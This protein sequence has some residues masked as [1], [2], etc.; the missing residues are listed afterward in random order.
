NWYA[1]ILRGVANHT[2][3]IEVRMKEPDKPDMILFRHFGDLPPN[4][5]NLN[6][7]A[8]DNNNQPIPAHASRY[9]P[10][11]PQP[12]QEELD[13]DFS[14]VFNL[15]ARIYN[16]TALTVKTAK[17][18]PTLEFTGGYSY[19]Y[20]AFI[21]DGSNH[22]IEVLKNGVVQQELPQLAAIVGAN[23]HLDPNNTVE[24]KVVISGG[25][26]TVPLELP[27]PTG[28]SKIR[29]EIYV[30]NSPFDGSL[31]AGHSEVAEYYKVIEKVNGDDIPPPE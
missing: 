22:K 17:T 21:K 18:R 20:T 5:P 30:D 14:L 4:L 15:G 26:L 7:T 31:G 11:F 8:F 9:I 3:S 2:L 29:Y 16:N 24:G 6:I 12:P 28:N 13:K 10:L 23:L 27:K 1:E 19:L 25:P